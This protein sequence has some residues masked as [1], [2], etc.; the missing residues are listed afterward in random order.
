MASISPAPQVLTTSGAR[1]CEYVRP[2]TGA[3]I[4]TG[5][6][7]ADGQG[8]AQG[9]RMPSVGTAAFLGRTS[10]HVSFPRPQKNS[11]SGITTTSPP[12]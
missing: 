11:V 3:W 6:V 4:P 12:V 5:V 8:T 9:T 2:S 10:V 1:V 7:T